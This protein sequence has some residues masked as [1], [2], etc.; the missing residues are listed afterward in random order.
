VKGQYYIGQ[1]SDEHSLKCVASYLNESWPLAY[2]SYHCK[3]FNVHQKINNGRY[4]KAAINYYKERN[5]LR[6]DI[7]Y[8]FKSAYSNLAVFD[9]NGNCIPTEKQRYI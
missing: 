1:I 8:A 5:K 3:G 7:Q 6:T 9:K 2:N 4:I